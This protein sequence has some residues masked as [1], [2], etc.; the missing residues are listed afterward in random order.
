MKASAI[1]I[2]RPERQGNLR[3]AFFTTITLIAWT[4]WMYLWLPLVT[5]VAWT[6]GLHTT[7]IELFVLEHGHGGSD[8]RIVLVAAVV[9]AAVFMAWSSYNRFRFTGRVRRQSHKVVTAEDSARALGVSSTTAT[10]MRSQQRLVLSFTDSGNP[11]L[12]ESELK[13]ITATVP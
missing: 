13:A 3:R 2:Q 8:L 10:Q 7:Y 4:F 12:G 11:V 6:L 1:I 9:A 5:L